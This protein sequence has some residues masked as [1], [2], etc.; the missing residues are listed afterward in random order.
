MTEENLK[1]PEN[2]RDILPDEHVYATFIKKVFR[3]RCRQSGYRRITPSILEK[4]ELLEMV[5]GKSSSIYNK[6][7]V[8][9]IDGENVLR[10]D[11]MPG[12]I[13][14]Y[15]QNECK[16]LPKPVELYSIEEVYRYKGEEKK[17]TQHIQMEGSVIGEEDA[18]MDAQVIYLAHKILKDLG[19]RDS[20]VLKIN[21][22]GSK[23]CQYHYKEELK[24]FYYGKEHVLGDEG[25][26]LL[27]S[28]PIRLL[29]SKNEDLAILAQLAP[30]FEN[31][32]DEYSVKNYNTVK[33]YIE[34]LD[35]EYEESPIL[36]GKTD[37]HTNTIFSF[38]SKDTGATI[39]SGG[40]YN[41]IIEKLTGEYIPALGFS[42]NFDKIIELM[43]KEEIYI[44]SKDTVDVFVAQ[45]GMEAKKKCLP[46][47]MK[48]REVGVH[49]IGAL[50]KGSMKEQLAIADKFKA[51]WTILM[52]QIEVLEGI[53]I[54]RNMAAGSQEIVQYDE[55]VEEI[56]QRLGED[57]LDKYSVGVEETVYKGSTKI[58]G[59]EYPP[60]E[61]EELV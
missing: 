28:N 57:M 2:L 11:L 18:A 27:E 58:F 51:S 49:A 50:G 48:L 34:E 1:S 33:S 47:M 37:N 55:L 42:G 17:L 36:I 45:L 32:L 25:I 5:L 4:K 10:P 35:I 44:K 15:I 19:I 52:G 38:V 6:L 46:I 20:V 56:I 7:Y 43:K 21:N 23:E 14:A 60:E 30:K 24:N 40:R 53:A 26:K 41:W 3:H 29:S 8:D 54:I 22:L 16:K 13:R 12:L 39:I 31:S 61:K 9:K 59:E